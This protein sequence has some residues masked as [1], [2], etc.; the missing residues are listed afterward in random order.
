MPVVAHHACRSPLREVI[1]LPV[2]NAIE[3]AADVATAT[4]DVAA[5]TADVAAATADVAAATVA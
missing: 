1:R 2:I 4:A 5:A 3:A